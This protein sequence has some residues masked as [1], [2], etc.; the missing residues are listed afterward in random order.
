M[1]KGDYETVMPL[2]VKRKLGIKY[3][4]QPIFTQQLGIFSNSDDFF[5]LEEII[6]VLK[7][8]YFFGFLQF[9]AFFQNYSQNKIK[10]RENLILKLNKPYSEIFSGFKPN[11][12]R[13]IKKAQ[14]YNLQIEHDISIQVLKEFYR[15]V[16]WPEK[17]NLKE[18]HYQLLLRLINGALI[19]RS[20]EIV[21]AFHK[22]QLQ[23]IVIGLLF[24]KRLTYLFPITSDQGYDL[25]VQFFLVDELI[26]IYSGKG[27]CIDFEGSSIEGVARFYKGFGAETENYFQLRFNKNI[28]GELILR[29]IN[30]FS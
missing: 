11:H 9:N 6:Y 28:L 27:I 7:S 5:T 3:I 24:N 15:K 23:S 10:V 19:N 25:G 20:C 13:N 17:Y 2:P 30:Y 16:A 29:A 1:V 18:K 26:K 22:G 14:K 8:N 21:G 12:K 4:A